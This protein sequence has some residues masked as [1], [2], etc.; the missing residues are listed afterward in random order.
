MH[1]ENR[2]GTFGGIKGTARREGAE[3][4]SEIRIKYNAIYKM[5]CIKTTQ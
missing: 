4:G 5:I 3:E 2:R 1:H